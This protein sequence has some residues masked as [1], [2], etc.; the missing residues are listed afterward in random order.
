M[1][2]KNKAYLIAEI[3][4]NRQLPLHVIKEITDVTEEDLYMLQTKKKIEQK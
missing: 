2:K 4:L 3:L 1:K